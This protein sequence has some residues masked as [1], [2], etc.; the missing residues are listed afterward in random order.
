[1]TTGPFEK[2]AER[3][4]SN[5]QQDLKDFLRVVCDDGDLDDS[6]RRTA[7]G[8]VL[9]AL[10]PGDVIPDSSGPLGFLDDALAL[11]LVLETVRTKA[12]DRFRAYEARITDMTASLD[13]DLAAAKGF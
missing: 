13:E 8:A 4:L 2:V 6:L 5:L 1:M 12:P 10:S 11:R 7:V 9:Y 3:W